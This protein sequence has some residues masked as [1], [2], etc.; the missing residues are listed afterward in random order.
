MG[1]KMSL[2]IDSIISFVTNGSLGYHD[3]WVVPNPMEL[4]S[5]G[6]QMIIAA[7]AISSS[8]N[9]LIRS[10]IGQNLHPNMEYDHP[11]LPTWVVESPSSYDLLNFKIS[12]DE[13]IIKVMASFV[14]PKEYVKH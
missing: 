7:I 2:C 13:A 1:L 3:P 4:E 9:S 5:Y 8:A 12:K 10:E 6:A 14:N 11:T